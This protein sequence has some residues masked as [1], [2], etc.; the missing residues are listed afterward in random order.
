MRKMVGYDAKYWLLNM[1]LSMIIAFAAVFCIPDIVNW[2]IG[3]K[4]ESSTFSI[5]GLVATMG[6]CFLLLILLKRSRRKKKAL[7]TVLGTIILLV[8]MAVALS[9]LCGIMA[10]VFYV[11]FEKLLN[12]GQIKGVIDFLTTIVVMLSIPLLVS[13]FWKEMWMEEGIGKAFLFGFS[14]NG[15]QYIRLLALTCILFGIGL[16]ISIAFHYATAD[17]LTQIMKVLFFT[18]MGTVGMAVSEKIVME[19]SR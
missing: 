2:S 8:I 19:G 10:L 11:L 17:V 1:L 16:L 6:V 13:V 18:A 12:F 3:A 7:L 9:M 5:V 14:M 15:K 4:T